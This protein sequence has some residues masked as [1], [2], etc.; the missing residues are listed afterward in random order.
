MIDRRRE[1]DELREQFSILGSTGNVGSFWLHS[2]VSQLRRYIKLPL[3]A[4]LD[5][6][7]STM[8]SNAVVGL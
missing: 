6:T 4:Y 7:V 2:H 1:G 3:I 5:V 8:A